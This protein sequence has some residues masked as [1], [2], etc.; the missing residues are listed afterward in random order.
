MAGSTITSS[1]ETAAPPVWREVQYV[2]SPGFPQ[3]LREADLSLLLSTYQAGKLVALSAAGESL[4]LEFANFERPMGLAVR[5]D[6]LAVGSRNQVW[7]HRNV[8]DVARQLEPAGQYDACYV[9]RTAH[10]TGDIQAHEMAW[11]DDTLWVVNTLFSCLCTLD[12]NYSFAPRW[13]PPFVSALAAEDRCHLNGVAL[14]NGSPR[15]VTVMA[16]SDVRQGWR[17]TKATSGC[18][19]D[20]RTGQTVVC[21][22]SMPHSPRISDGELFVLDSGRGQLLRISPPSGSRD[23]VAEVPGYARGLAIHG[24]LAF[25]GLSRI[26]ETSTFGGL[27]LESRRNELRCGVAAIHIPSGQTLATFEFLSGVE[28]LFDVAVLPGVRFPAL[29]GPFSITDRRAEIWILRDPAR[30]M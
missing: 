14:E 10:V 18:L 20:V 16:E 13:M 19:I 22:L 28:E 23:V 4:S 15:F 24:P 12:A 17:P 25:V 7:L 30:Q 29:R 21:G 1:T 11:S 26:R 5:S 9:A 2:H 6:R 8:P 27:P 3:L